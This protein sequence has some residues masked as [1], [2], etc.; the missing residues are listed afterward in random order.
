M[1]KRRSPCPISCV[2]ELLGDKWTLLLIRDLMAGKSTFGDFMR[3]PEKISTNI[4]SERLARL[5]ESGLVVTVPS[6]G[7]EAYALSPRG[8]SLYSVMG[9]IA[10][11]GLE[12]LEGTEAL[13]DV[14]AP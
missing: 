11:W 3:S 13:I 2:L 6:G 1:P 4:L 14:P 10:R 12:N 7:R 9:A 5:V 8:R